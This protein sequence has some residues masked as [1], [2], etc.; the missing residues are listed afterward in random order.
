MGYNEARGVLMGYN[1]ARGALSQKH[2]EE[3]SPGGPPDPAQ[4]L[5]QPISS[6]ATFG[7]TMNAAITGHTFA[8]DRPTV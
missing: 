5:P 6:G 7:S 2:G 1:E 3:R 4:D 8:T